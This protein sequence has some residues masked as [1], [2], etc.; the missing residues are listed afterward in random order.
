[1]CSNSRSTGYSWEHF[2]A[3]DYTEATVEWEQWAVEDSDYV[4]RARASSVETSIAEVVVRLWN[5]TC[6][7]GGW[8]YLTA[9]SFRNELDVVVYV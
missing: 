5:E 6:P 2:S 9:I 4:P 3:I 1:M 7:G 8:A